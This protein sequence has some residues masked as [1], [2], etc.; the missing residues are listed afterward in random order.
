MAGCWRWGGPLCPQHAVEDLQRSGFWEQTLVSQ[1]PL[2]QKSALDPWR[3]RRAG[4]RDAELPCNLATAWRGYTASRSPENGELSFVC[5]RNLSA[6]P[7]VRVLV[8]LWVRFLD[9]QRVFSWLSDSQ[10]WF[11]SWRAWPHRARSAP[12]FPSLGSQKS[13][14]SAQHTHQT[15]LHH[16][17]WYLMVYWFGSEKDGRR[18]SFRQAKAKTSPRMKIPDGP[19]L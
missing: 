1:R 4:W 17:W 7:P 8:P 19:T 12:Q 3:R 9:R 11:H 10:L 6:L 13:W 16:S 2:E 5:F 15:P 14:D 18:R